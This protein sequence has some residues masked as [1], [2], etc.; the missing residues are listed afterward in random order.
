MPL[1]K[2]TVQDRQGLP[3]PE[4]LI[5]VEYGTVPYPDMAIFSDEEGNFSIN[6]P[7][8][9]FRL[10]GHSQDGDYG[11]V[12]CDSDADEHLLIHLSIHR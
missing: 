8:G 5:A 12:E 7:V 1:V 6:L 9:H 2:G 10:A 4:A 11:T 3:V